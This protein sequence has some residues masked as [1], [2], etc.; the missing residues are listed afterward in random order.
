[1]FLRDGEYFF[2]IEM[3]EKIFLHNRNKEKFAITSFAITSISSPSLTTV[4]LGLKGRG[5][6]EFG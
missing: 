4:I 2:R 6:R 3:K 5:S 1:V